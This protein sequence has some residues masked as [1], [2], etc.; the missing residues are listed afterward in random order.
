ME[1]KAGDRVRVRWPGQKGGSCR[2]EGGGKAAS[3]ELLQLG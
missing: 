1:G 3:D 2:R